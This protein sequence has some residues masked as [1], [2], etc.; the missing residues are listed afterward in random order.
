MPPASPPPLH[1]TILAGPS[2]Y[3]MLGATGI[4]MA[5]LLKLNLSGPGVTESV[6]SL[7]RKKE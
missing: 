1:L 4:T 2:R 5:G 3:I 7:W 6:K